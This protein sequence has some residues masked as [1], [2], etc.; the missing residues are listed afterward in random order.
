MAVAVGRQW[1]DPLL[2]A[3]SDVFAGP[4]LEYMVSE[5]DMR[6]VALICHFSLDRRSLLGDAPAS[7]FLASGAQF[8]C[9]PPCQ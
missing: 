9:A 7:R 6:R 2:D 1:R 4:V 8:G 3:M 5:V